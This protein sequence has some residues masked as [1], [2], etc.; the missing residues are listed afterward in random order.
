MQPIIGVTPS[1]IDNRYA[2]GAKYISKIVEL[3][4]VPIIF[5]YQ[6][7][8]IPVY[9]KM[10]SGL[11][12]SGGG[13]I[14]AKH[15]NQVHHEKASKPNKERDEFEIELCRRAIQADIPYLGIC[16]GAQVLNVALG[17]DLNQ[18]FEGHNFDG[19]RRVNYIH[20]VRLEP[21]SKFHEIIG[22]DEIRVNSIHHQ[23]VGEKLGDG[24]SV[25]AF[26]SEEGIIEA[27]EARSKKFVIG[28]Q[29]HP[30]ELIDAYS[31]NLF[32]AFV[33]AARR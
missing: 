18:H 27:I 23:S 14:D 20:N 31:A 6:L 29:W 28:V 9:M 26:S 8:N 11:L 33:D 17:G 1:F 2:V 5:S 4:A 16:R 25:C 24:I 21:G 10:V 7:E 13:D 12:F 32:K 3:G 30:E 15:F 22:S 19:D